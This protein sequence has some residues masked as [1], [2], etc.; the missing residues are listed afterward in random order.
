MRCQPLVLNARLLA[1]ACGSPRPAPWSSPSAHAPRPDLLF[2]VSDRLAAEG[3][4]DIPPASIPPHR[5]E[6]GESPHGGL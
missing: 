1:A 2:L 5:G 6:H 4:I 3:A